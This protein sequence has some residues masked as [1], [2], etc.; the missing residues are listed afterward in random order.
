MRQAN[1]LFECSC[2]ELHQWSS[3]AWQYRFDLWLHRN[4][5][6]CLEI[7]K[8]YVLRLCREREGKS[9]LDLA[10]KL[11][12]LFLRDTYKSLF[13]H[14]CSNSGRRVCASVR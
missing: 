14:A 2:L 10:P 4:L 6:A 5:D 7:N 12:N 1:K 3:R 13:G 11:S 8:N 9:G